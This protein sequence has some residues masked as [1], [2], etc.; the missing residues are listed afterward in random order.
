[1]WK[2]LGQT[3][4]WKATCGP[5]FSP[6]REDRSNLL[7]VN[8]LQRNFKINLAYNVIIVVDIGKFT[9]DFID[10]AFENLT[11]VELLSSLLSTSYGNSQH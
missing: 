1:M 11:F 8:N 7:K 4:P 3:S 10:N 2:C 9:W 5:Y 6:D